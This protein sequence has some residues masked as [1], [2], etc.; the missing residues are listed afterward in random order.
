MS[1]RH[2]IGDAD[3]IDDLQKR[4]GMFDGTFDR[5]LDRMFDEVTKTGVR[6]SD[7]AVVP[8]T[9]ITRLA[10]TAQRCG[11]FDGM[12]DRTFDRM[13]DEVVVPSTGILRVAGTG[14]RNTAQHMP[15]L[16]V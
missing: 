8:A 11:M 12:F 14:Q 3:V 4:C 2:A 7:E 10:R 13:F 5:M 16:D 1:A 9:G 6:P 15:M